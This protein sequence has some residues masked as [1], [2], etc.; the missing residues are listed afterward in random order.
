MIEELADGIWTV[1]MPLQLTG[2]EFG[3]RMT[4]V[5]VGDDGLVLISPCSIDDSLASEINALGTVRAVIAPNAFH[6]RYFAD[7]IERYPGASRFFAEGVAK[8]VESTPTD[9]V[10][11]GAEAD[12]KRRTRTVQGRRRAAGERGRL[13]PCC[14][15]NVGSDGSVFQFQS[16]TGGIGRDSTAPLRRARATGGFAPDATLVE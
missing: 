5:R 12:L 11:L 7:A 6:H 14:V 4:I 10:T 16:G 2:I 15:E 8:K 9:T 3:T 13:L 1:A